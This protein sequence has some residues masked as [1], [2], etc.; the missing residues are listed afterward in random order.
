MYLHAPDRTTP[1]AETMEAVDKEYRA[2]KFE[3]FGLSNFNAA[4]VEECVEI[5]RKNGY[6][7]PTVY[8]GHYNAIT[9]G[10]EE[11]LFPV[12]RKHG[13][14]FYAYRYVEG[15]SRLFFDVHIERERE[16]S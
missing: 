5:C 11:T 7:V 12:L 4:E 6:V 3:E 8:Q 13:M 10:A 1:F 16:T 2:G 9:R 14:R 15:E